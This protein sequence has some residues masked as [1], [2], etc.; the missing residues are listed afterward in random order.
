MTEAVTVSSTGQEIYPADDGL[1]SEPAV[2]ERPAEDNRYDPAAAGFIRAAFA[3]AQSAP[4]KERWLRGSYHPDFNRLLGELTRQLEAVDTELPSALLMPWRCIDEYMGRKGQK[5]RR[6]YETLPEDT[7]EKVNALRRVKTDRT[8]EL[9][10]TKIV[11]ALANQTLPVG[12]LETPPYCSQQ[13]DFTSRTC[14]NASFR[15][16]FAALTGERL[17]QSSVLMGL[18]RQLGLDYYQAPLLHD[19]EYLALLQTAAFKERYGKT[20]RNISL[21][22]AGFD[23]ITAI[24]TRLRLQ[25][26]ALRIFCMV[27]LASD[28]PAA[29]GAWHSAILLAADEASVM[30]HDPSLKRGAPARVIPKADFTR[31]WAETFLS[32]Q[33]VAAE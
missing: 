19:E 5:L 13:A 11:P 28:S 25:N 6:L 3:E 30:L 12:R 14:A 22:G 27:S 21:S 32:G 8:A 18:Q 17:T 9:I 7:L 10:E 4:P 20:V 29:Q 16:L 1:W 26:P 31:R 33:L 23:E 15:M 24:A 2:V